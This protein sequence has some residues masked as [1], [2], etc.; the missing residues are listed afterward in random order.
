MTMWPLS[1]LMVILIL[2]YVQV[3]LSLD[4]ALT[5]A[6]LTGSLNVCMIK[7][8]TRWMYLF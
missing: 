6:Y 8:K 3:S 7:G 1:H 4:R 2:L 5:L